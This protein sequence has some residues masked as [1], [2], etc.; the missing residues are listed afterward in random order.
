MPNT[1]L[2]RR[3]Q[4]VVPGN[5]VEV[6]DHAAASSAD[7]VILDLEDS[8]RSNEKAVAREQ[9]VDAIEENDWGGKIVS[10]RINGLNTRWWYE[11]VVTL[12]TGAGEEIDSFVLPKTDS[13]EMVTGLD[14]LLTQVEVNAGLPTN[15]IGVE[16]QIESALGMSNVID[17]AHTGERLDS[18]I[19]GPGDYSASIG[20]GGLTTGHS[21]QY[22]GHY[23]H[24]ALSRL[25]HAA[26]GAGLQAIDG[27]FA[28][29]E[30]E[31]GFQEACNQAKMVGCDGK[32]VIHPKQV[33][34]ANT[35]FAPTE[36]QA[37]LA[38]QI[39]EAYETARQEG[40]QTATFEGEVIDDATYQ[41]AKNMVER[42]EQ[43][44]VL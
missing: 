24:Y 42:A 36:E 1:N 30:D 15:S 13:A 44:G 31:E 39:T 3:S 34:H 32:W 26:K 21:N 37:R 35:V 9:V 18:L 40:Q 27:L 10:C 5:D 6:L 14:F 2:L 17:I 33:E 19:F 43:A 38:T 28:D 41:M 29:F 22:P 4:L 16:A 20:V 23:W 8:V 25:V 7:E 11:D 12:G